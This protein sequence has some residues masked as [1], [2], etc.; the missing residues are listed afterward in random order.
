MRSQTLLLV[1]A[2]TLVGPD[3]VG[4]SDL[5]AQ[6]TPPR[7][8]MVGGRQ[9]LTGYLKPQVTSAKVVGRVP[10]STLI[11]LSVGLPTRNPQELQSL[12]KK[13]SDPASPM[14]RKYLTPDEFAARFSPTPSDYQALID[15]AKAKHLSIVLTHPNRMLLNVSGNAADIQAAFGV[16][17]EYALRADGSKFYRPDREPSL[18]TAVPVLA[19]TGMDDFELPKRSGGSSPVGNFI[20]NDL[21][22]AYVPCTSLAG[23][24]QSLGILAFDGYNPADVAQYQTVAGIPHLVPTNVLAGGATGAPSGMSAETVADIELAMA[25]APGLAHLTVYIGKTCNDRDSLLSQM[26]TNQPLSFQNSSSYG[27]GPGLNTVALFDTM[28]IQGQSFFWVSGDFGGYGPNSQPFDVSKVTTVGGTTLTMNGAGA[29]YQSEVTWN[30]PAINRS[31]GGGVEGGIAIPPYQ[32]GSFSPQSGASS[33]NRNDPDVS[34]VAKDLYIFSSNPFASGFEGTSAAAP[35][36]AGFM[37][38]VNQQNSANGLPPVWAAPA[39]WHIGRTPPAYALGFHDI[40]SGTATSYLGGPNYSAGPGYDLATGWGTPECGL[41]DQLACVACNGTTATVGQPPACAQLQ[42]DPNNCGTCGHACG[43][44]SGT[45][46]SRLVPAPFVPLPDWFTIPNPDP[47]HHPLAYSVFDT[48][49]SGASQQEFSFGTNANVVTRMGFA[50]TGAGNR[51]LYLQSIVFVDPANGGTQAGD[52]WL[53]LNSDDPAV[54]AACT[55]NCDAHDSV[56]IHIHVTSATIGDAKTPALVEMFTKTSGGTSIWTRL[57]A[58]NPIAVPAWLIGTARQWVS[59]NPANDKYSWAVAL[60]VPVRLGQSSSDPTNGVSPNASTG[61]LSV[62]YELDVNAPGDPLNLIAYD[63]PSNVPPLAGANL[64]EP[65]W[66]D[67]RRFGTIEF[68][69]ACSPEVG[70]GAADISTDQPDNRTLSR[71]GATVFQAVAHLSGAPG[72]VAN[73]VTARFRI[74]DWGSQALGQFNSGD[75][76]WLEVGTSTPENLTLPATPTATLTSQPWTPPGGGNWFTNHNEHQ[77][78]Y[79]EL[80]GTSGSGAHYPNGI[81][82]SPA[83]AW[84]NLNRAAASRFERQARISIKGLSP[85]NTPQPQRDVYIYFEPLNL[86]ARAA[87]KSPPTRQQASFRSAGQVASR[88]ENVKLLAENPSQRLLP[89]PEGEVA[90][91]DAPQYRVHVYHDTGVRRVT[92]GAKEVMLAAQGSFG[93]LV[94][95]QGLND[96]THFTYATD[97]DQTAPQGTSETPKLIRITNDYYRLSIDEGGF[98]TVKTTITADEGSRVLWWVWLLVVLALLMA[99]ILVVIRVC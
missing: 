68:D 67:Y 48:A 69:A 52:L 56:L 59:A 14:Y 33:T 78:M 65:T 45:C 7:A 73:G 27:C 29:S 83:S 12:L 60:R 32:A 80:S 87:T 17:L 6:G 95:H 19:I 81:L 54:L 23:A 63:F 16:N 4:G 90:R 26:T 96:Q 13:V 55:T 3:H 28:A 64:P 30:D 53:A 70:I 58:P 75:T 37:A 77:C 2:L 47:T 46:A 43:P 34:M 22:R 85:M 36:W 49:W 71:N 88:E 62:A 25:M 10:P 82:F 21:R 44:P 35:L 18:D 5:H 91:L 76:P 41:I 15:W 86:P 1:I 9:Q 20:S 89:L 24:G 11:R 38:L 74:A 8:R 40:T 99:V 98:V 93:Y 84:T 39:I 94:D 51:D 66:P 50:D 79:V 61:K 31:S 42:T 57:G 72:A 92:G 97:I